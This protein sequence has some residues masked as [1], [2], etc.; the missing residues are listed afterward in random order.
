[1]IEL[2][3]IIIVILMIHIEQFEISNVISLS[4]TRTRIAHHGDLVVVF[5]LW[6][7]EQSLSRRLGLAVRTVVTLVFLLWISDGITLGEEA[8][9]L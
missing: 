1:M 5:L 9:A 2:I 6:L 8:L 3:Y 4:Q 7:L